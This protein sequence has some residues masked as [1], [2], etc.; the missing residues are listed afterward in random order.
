MNAQT[1]LANHQ[2]KQLKA[3]DL[4]EVRRYTKEFLDSKRHTSDIAEIIGHFEFEPSSP[5][6]PVEGFIYLDTFYIEKQKDGSYITTIENGEV[7]GTMEEV[8]WCLLEWALGHDGIV[9]EDLSV[10]QKKTYPHELLSSL[11]LE[12]GKEKVSLYRS[13]L[14]L[15]SNIFEAFGSTPQESHQFLVDGLRKHGRETDC[16]D[17]DFFNPYLGLAKTERVSLGDC[18]LIP[19]E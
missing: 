7:E 10:T 3:H 8:E 4:D 1:W 15:D 5:R 12:E 11:E 18:L 17:E 16:I 6:V 14:V 19:N 9:V 13:I 2:A